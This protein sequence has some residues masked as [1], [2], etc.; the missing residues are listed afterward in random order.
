L[1]TIL[2]IAPVRAGKLFAFASVEVDIDGVRLEIHGIRAMRVTPLRTTIELPRFRDSTGVS[3][4]A[5]ALPEEVCA[6]IESIVLDTLVERGLARQ[7]LPNIDL[8]IV[9]DPSRATRAGCS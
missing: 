4:P 7:I 2:S 5:L 1:I 6:A 9:S 8:A 3:R